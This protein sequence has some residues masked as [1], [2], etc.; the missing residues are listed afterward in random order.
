[1]DKRDE[2]IMFITNLL[3]AGSVVYAGAKTVIGQ[4]APTKVLQDRSTINSIDRTYASARSSVEVVT[5]EPIGLTLA[6]RR[7]RAAAA[8]SFWLSVG[9]L[10]WTPFTLAS[11]PLTLYST[12]PILEAGCQSLYAEGRLKPSVI[13][14]ILLVSTLVTDHYL[15]AAMITWLHHAFRQLGR[16]AQIAGE[17][18]TTEVNNE[19]GDLLRQAMGG[20]PRTA[21]VINDRTANE[22]GAAESATVEMK[23]PFGDLKVGDTVIINR[24]EFIP[25]EG[26]VTAGEAKVNL[27]LLTRSPT[28]VDVG[29]GDKVYPATLL[30]E[31]RLRVQVEKIPRQ[32]DQ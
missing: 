29:I 28:P 32:P 1:V 7:H 23:V 9:G 6:E 13:N 27:F 5:N 31:G 16:Q 11:I 17:Q 8:T 25:V 22:D 4:R 12:V 18:L 21:W 19:L 2:E 15:P 20:T 30:V 24:G 14:S 26:I 3:V 10:F